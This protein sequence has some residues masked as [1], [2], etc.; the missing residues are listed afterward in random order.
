MIGIFIGIAAVVSLIA[1]GQGMQ[2][3]INEQFKKVG[4]NRITISPGGRFYGPASSELT[5]SKLKEHD[6]NLIKKVKGVDHAMGVLSKTL[7][8]KF[9]DEIKYVNI[10]G[11][12][13]DP[14]SLEM[15]KSIGFFDIESGRS[16]KGTDKYK[17]DIGN[18]VA[19]DTFN[20]GIKTRDKIKIG[21]KVFDIVGVRKK[22]GTG[23]HDIV[24][25]IPMDTAREM[26]DEPDEV[27][28]IFAITKQGFVT[29]N[30]A[31]SI[32]KALR[33]DRN[34]KEGD[35]DFSVQTAE[36][37]IAQ[38]NTILNVVQVVLIGIAS[39][40]LL[41]GGIGIMNTMYTSVLER[42][43]EIGIMKSIGARNSD[44]LI[45]FLIE[46][47]VLGLIGGLIGVLLGIG[48]SKLG[49]LIALLYNVT[50]LKAQITIILVI[51]A[52]LFSFFV[53]SISGILPAIQASRLS[54]VDAL[55][56][57]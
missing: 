12:P 10:M 16:I 46:S 8:V 1:L 6:V 3:A 50:Q 34:L 11:T 56:K 35:E 14:K 45:I 37:T 24:I 18:I 29:K 15:M 5:V 9:K 39:I 20:K 25:R 49:E 13:T 53:G 48:I 26:F 51:G 33:K 40:S 55:R 2:S 43:R 21:D 41:V 32:K 17:A 31:E 38:L 7:K 4:S 27:S 42:T 52:L 47:G 19:Y 23:V 30:V 57:K 28:L 44:I 54:P 36:Q 22:V